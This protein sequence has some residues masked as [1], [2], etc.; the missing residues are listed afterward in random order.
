MKLNPPHKMRA[1]PARIGMQKDSLPSDLAA[2]R[3]TCTGWNDRVS[4]TM[5]ADPAV[6]LAW[7]NCD[8]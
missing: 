5:R 7:A 2:S 4:R 1:P 8:D 3:H 6:G